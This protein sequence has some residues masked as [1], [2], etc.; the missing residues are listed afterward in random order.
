MLTHSPCAHFCS[1]DLSVEYIS[2]PNMTFCFFCRYFSFRFVFFFLFRHNFSFALF[3]VLLI[4]ASVCISLSV[5]F[6]KFTQFSWNKLFV[7]VS[8]G[9]VHYIFKSKRI[10]KY[11][12][13]I[14]SH[15]QNV[16]LRSLHFRQIKNASS[17]ILTSGSRQKERERE[18]EREIENHS[19]SVRVLYSVIFSWV[20]SYN[21]LYIFVRLLNMN[22]YGVGYCTAKWC[23]IERENSKKI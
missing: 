2:V 17:S 14:C 11:H 16:D 12:M 1:M 10:L 7:F 23:T 4:H 9:T 8:G 22:T 3:D 13:W 18:R 20:L 5:R 15:A 19:M 21:F 6:H